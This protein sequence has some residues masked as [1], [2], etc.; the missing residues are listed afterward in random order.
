MGW[1]VDQFHSY[2][3]IRKLVCR[4]KFNHMPIVKVIEI[5]SSSNKSWEDAAQH[6]I[7]EAAKSLHNIK[8]LYIKEHSVVVDQK[9]MIKEFRITGSLSFEVETPEKNIAK[10]G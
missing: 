3:K 8:S 9:N 10:K 5:M 2:R 1:Q 6:A 7:L 4:T